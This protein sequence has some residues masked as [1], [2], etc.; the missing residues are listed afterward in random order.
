MSA[1]LS[2]SVTS[3]EGYAGPL[4]T[5]EPEVF[6]T[7]DEYRRKQAAEWAEQ[8]KGLRVMRAEQAERRAWREVGGV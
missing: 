2:L 7:S 1:R 3:R 8:R 6:T 5:D 4:Y